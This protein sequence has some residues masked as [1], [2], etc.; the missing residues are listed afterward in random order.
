[1]DELKENVVVDKSDD[2]LDA[3][4][5]GI[6]DEVEDTRDTAEEIMEINDELS[7]DII[8]RNINYNFE[9]PT[10]Y[11]S[12]DYISKFSK[13]YADIAT[14]RDSDLER[15]ILLKAVNRITEEVRNGLLNNYNIEGD[16]N[17]LE[18]VESAPLDKLNDLD[19][20]YTFFVVRH[21]SNLKDYFKSVFYQQKKD[22]ASRYSD[23]LTAENSG[24]L[25]ISQDKHKFGTRDSA[26]L[27]NSVGDIIQDIRSEAEALG[28]SEFYTRVCNTD[29]FEEMNNRMF[30]ILDG[31]DKYLINDDNASVRAYLSIL[32]DDEIFSNLKADISMDILDDARLADNE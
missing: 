32:D 13:S 30:N 29:I 28:A 23:A 3:T 4:D 20:L 17:Y 11:E 15:E 7:L 1:M 25:F 12:I 10:V 19:T 5:D 26:I 16:E 31:K 21:Y 18:K 6:R 8:L 14:I 24:D 2:S 9:H 27:I 22:F